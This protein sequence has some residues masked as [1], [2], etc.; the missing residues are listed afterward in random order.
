[1]SGPPIVIVESGGVP[2]TEVEGGAPVFTEVATG[3]IPVTIVEGATPVII[4][5]LPEP[6]E[7]E[8]G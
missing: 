6:E 4:E 8:D 5:R 2:V 7:P 3:G 1:M